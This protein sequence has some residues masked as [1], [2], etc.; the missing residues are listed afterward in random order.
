MEPAEQER[1]KQQNNSVHTRVELHT[2]KI[3]NSY[4]QR[5]I[6]YKAGFGQCQP[7]QGLL[8]H[9]SQ[10]PCSPP[11]TPNDTPRA[12]ELNQVNDKSLLD[13]LIVRDPPR[14]E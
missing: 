14:V 13:S 12:E 3:V 2:K 5:R 10:A 6:L 1:K 11:K 9:S 4:K 8:R 7:S